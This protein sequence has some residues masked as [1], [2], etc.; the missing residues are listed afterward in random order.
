MNENKIT[1]LNEY[2]SENLQNEVMIGEMS[3]EMLDAYYQ[4]AQDDTP[5]LWSRVE[6]GFDAEYGT[7]KSEIHS[8]RLRKRK[9]RNAVAA[10]ILVTIIAV[11]VMIMMNQGGAKEESK[12]TEASNDI[13]FEMEADEEN[14]K[15]D[16]LQDESAMES[17]RE[18]CVEGENINSTE[19]QNESSVSDDGQTTT[20]PLQGEI[21][22]D[23]VLAARGEL[24]EVDYDNSVV[25][26]RVDKLCSSQYEEY[27]IETGD[28]ILI[29]N[30]MV[31]FTMD[32]EI[33]SCQIE[34][35]SMSLND[36]GEYEGR[37]KLIEKTEKN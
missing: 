18:E 29:T 16:Y 5:D 11:P 22:D 14:V 23:R 37:I 12:S 26:F 33:Y 17:T 24:V 13:A 6:Q 3:H 34:L 7:I 35:D 30:P 25:R 8:E 32:T 36:K 19:S 1:N 9:V 20:D 15:Q 21:T 27:S 2:K 28:V 31:I 10:V 4:M